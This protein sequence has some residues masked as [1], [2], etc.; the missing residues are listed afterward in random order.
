MN[1]SSR[2]DGSL[3]P[4]NLPD[5]CLGYDIPVFGTNYDRRG[6]PFFETPIQQ[7]YGEAG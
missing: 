5:A 4:T 2:L 7:P 6:S 1:V 3:M